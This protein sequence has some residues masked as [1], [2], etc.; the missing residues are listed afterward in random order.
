[1]QSRTPSAQLVPDEFGPYDNA[2][3]HQQASAAIVD[4][5]ELMAEQ[6]GH[7]P[8]RLRTSAARAATPPETE[9]DLPRSRVPLPPPKPEPDE[10]LSRFRV[11]LKQVGGPRT[12]IV[13]VRACSIKQAAERALSELAGSAAKPAGTWEVLEVSRA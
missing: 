8:S 6:E 2:Y 5:L 11:R 13:S 12:R 7:N 1:M 3:E 10:S 4:G 9:T